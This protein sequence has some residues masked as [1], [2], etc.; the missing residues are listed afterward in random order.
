MDTN[1][2][3]P[4][5]RLTISFVGILIV[6]FLWRWA[7]NHLYSLPITSIAA[8]T[9]ITTNTMYVVGALVVFF[10]TGK[11]IYDWKNTTTAEVINKFEAVISQTTVDPKHFD[12]LKKVP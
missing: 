5:Q 10:V 1:Q 4:W 7:T 8:F 2:R 11:L 12:D 6:V 9:S 3:T